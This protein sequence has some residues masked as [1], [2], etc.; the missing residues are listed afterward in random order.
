M[1]GTPAVLIS[2][3]FSPMLLTPGL[4]LHH[5]HP[6]FG[7]TL[8]YDMPNGLA[9]DF[10]REMGAADGEEIKRE[11]LEGDN[12]G[13]VCEGPQVSEDEDTAVNSMLISV[14]MPLAEV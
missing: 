10:V 3:N 6:E 4:S 14:L 7:E 9:I 1:H 12:G 11:H 13:R 5:Y 8:Q 2:R